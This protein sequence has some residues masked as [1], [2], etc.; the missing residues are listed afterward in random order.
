M[1]NQQP[2]VGLAH[3]LTVQDV[4]GEAYRAVPLVAAPSTV[5]AARPADRAVPARA[6]WRSLLLA[7]GVGALV[8]CLTLSV[9]FPKPLPVPNSTLPRATAPARDAATVAQAGRPASEPASMTDESADRTTGVPDTPNAPLPAVPDT[10]LPARPK[11]LPPPEHPAPTRPPHRRHDGA[12]PGT[13]IG[14]TNV[15][16][17]QASGETMTL[18]HFRDLQQG[19]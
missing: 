10:P 8:S 4:V 16:A 14:R 5:V 17:A 11:G 15:D 6:P 3:D 19:F 18:S 12:A 13:T 2:W 9:L 7:A 1:T